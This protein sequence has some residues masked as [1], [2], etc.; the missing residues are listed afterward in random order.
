M[1]IILWL[2]LITHVGEA[3]A[4]F[5]PDGLIDWLSQENAGDLGLPSHWLMVKFPMNYSDKSQVFFAISWWKIWMIEKV[6]GFCQNCPSIRDVDDL[7]MAAVTLGLRSREDGH[8]FIRFIH[9]KM[10]VHLYP[11]LVPPRIRSRWSRLAL[12]LFAEW[13]VPWG[14]IFQFFV[15]LPIDLG[16]KDREKSSATWSKSPHDQQN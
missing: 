5:H 16:L 12:S 7:F 2:I 14:D 15:S 6:F 8:R 9:L 1:V 13:K 10:L 11:K 4:T 3:T